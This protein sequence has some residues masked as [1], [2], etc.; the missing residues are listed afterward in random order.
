MRDKDPAVRFFYVDDSGA[1][2]TGWIVFSWIEC[3]IADWRVGLRGWLDLRKDLYA[4]FA[5]PPS[6]ELHSTKFLGGRGNPSTDPMHNASKETRR[7][8]M[9]LALAAIGGTPELRVGTVYRR[10]TARRKAFHK[11]SVQVYDRLVTVLNARL[12]AAGEHGLIFM[13]GNG[14]ATSYYAAHRALKLANRNI[15]EDPLFQPAHRSQWVQ[16]ADIVAYSAYQGLLRHPGKEFA[17]DW[18]AQYVQRIDVNGGPVA[19]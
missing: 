2:E 16:M 6:Y 14:T 3:A 5:I 8:A 12:G 4:E 9:A 11:E 13:D 7:Q 15:I 10:T 18:Y 17:W 1:S 19:L